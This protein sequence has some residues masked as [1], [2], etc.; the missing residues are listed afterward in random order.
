MEGTPRLGDHEETLRPG[1]SGPSQRPNCQSVARD[2]QTAT[3]KP[4]ALQSL[5]MQR[6]PAPLGRQ[7][8]AAAR[9]P[10]PRSFQPPQPIQ[11]LSAAGWCHFAGVNK[12]KSENGRWSGKQ[13]A[14]QAGSTRSPR[15][16]GRC[17][18][19][20]T[21]PGSPPQPAASCPPPRAGAP[22]GTPQPAGGRQSGGKPQRGEQW[23]HHAFEGYLRN[24]S[25]GS[26][27]ARL[28]VV[29]QRGV[30]G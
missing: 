7:G 4:R 20:S 6:H 29:R 23:L 13:A 19:L 8:Q 22:P 11:N 17:K 3:G 24:E 14:G 1:A 26:R 21:A 18:R 25:R 16:S 5:S 10:P 9:R 2:P 30:A 12:I 28:Y 27:Q 15:S